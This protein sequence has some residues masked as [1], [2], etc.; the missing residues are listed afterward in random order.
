MF[1]EINKV[2]R[3][4]NHLQ[5]QIN[6]TVSR[7]QV[8]QVA[9]LTMFNHTNVIN[10]NTNNCTYS[11]QRNNV[12]TINVNARNETSG[13]GVSNEWVNNTS[14]KYRQA[15]NNTLNNNNTVNYH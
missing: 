10:N 14:N 6:T 2:R 3:C 11:Q 15:I 12:P 4:L 5:C 9:A 13:N 7:K 8:H 1:T